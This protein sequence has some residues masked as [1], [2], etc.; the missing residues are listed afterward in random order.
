MN[1][2]EQPESEGGLDLCG[3]DDI[4]K[5]QAPEMSQQQEPCNHNHG[6][7][8]DYYDYYGIHWGQHDYGCGWMMPIMS[9]DEGKEPMF[10]VDE[11]PK[12][13]K[14]RR[15]KARQQEDRKERL[16]QEAGWSWMKTC[17]NKEKSEAIKKSMI[18][19]ANQSWRLTRRMHMST[20]E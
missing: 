4:E 11:S 7:G 13:K 12:S 16:R 14:E 6:W 2:A 3:G 19:R 15:R 9:K 20:L 18:R 10:E 5:S 1:S 17:A 8:Y